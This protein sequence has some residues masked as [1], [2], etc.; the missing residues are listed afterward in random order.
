MG[1]SALKTRVFEEIERIPENKLSELYTFIRYFRLG[2]EAS[3]GDARQIMA[4]AGCW[5]DMPDKVFAEFSREIT[6]R[7]RQAF[8]RRRSSETYSD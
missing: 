1:L 7:R 5:D 8:S 2:L 3:Q 6:E 4:F